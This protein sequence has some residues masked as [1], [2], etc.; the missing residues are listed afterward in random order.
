M[1][2]V[3]AMTIVTLLC[4]LSVAGCSR[5]QNTSSSGNGAV[6]TT[7]TANVSGGGGGVTTD[8]L[9]ASD[10]VDAT[11]A[12]IDLVSAGT[13]DDANNAA[14]TLLSFNPPQPVVTDISTVVGSA[15]T[16]TPKASTGTA[17][18]GNPDW[19]KASDDIGN[20]ID[21]VCPG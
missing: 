16:T 4:I 7:T 10:C 15:A 8:S 17:K 20:W 19:Q 2:R 3:V 21:Q 5:R 13:T 6:T 18:N 1:K 11:G 14:A 9:S 12:Y